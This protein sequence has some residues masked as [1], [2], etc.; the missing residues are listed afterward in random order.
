MDSSIDNFVSYEVIVDTGAEVNKVS[1]DAVFT[2]LTDMAYKSLKTVLSLPLD[3]LVNVQGQ[4]TFIGKVF[5]KT[6]AAGITYD[7]QI[8]QIA[9]KQRNSVSM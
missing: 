8:I 7:T 1:S 4:L 3:E 5:S 6:T 9:D 2:P